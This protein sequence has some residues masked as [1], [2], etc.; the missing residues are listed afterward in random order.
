MRPVYL[1]VAAPANLGTDVISVPEGSDL[2][3]DLRLEAVMEGVLV[4]GTVH[5]HAKGECV[6]CLGDVETDLDVPVMDLFA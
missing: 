5:A 6:R 2:D 1:T 4:S 3:L